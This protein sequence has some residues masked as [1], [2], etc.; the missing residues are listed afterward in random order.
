MH[1]RVAIYECAWGFVCVCV[2]VFMCSHQW[3]FSRAHSGHVLAPMW[4]DWKRRYT[5]IHTA[6]RTLRMPGCVCVPVWTVLGVSSRVSH[7]ISLFSSPLFSLLTY[8]EM[9]TRKYKQNANQ[10]LHVCI[11]L[12]GR[13]LFVCLRIPVVV[14]ALCCCLLV[15]SWQSRSSSHTLTMTQL[16]SHLKYDL[17]FIHLLWILSLHLTLPAPHHFSFHLNFYFFFNPSPVPSVIPHLL[18]LPLLLTFLPSLP[19]TVSHP[20][21]LPS[22]SSHYE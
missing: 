18:S 19:H 20:V 9:S 6:T 2:C 21:C 14:V 8:K 15:P 1:G 5:H 22:T 3:Q 12:M 13:C 10:W 11:W 16:P 17:T 7:I 4:E